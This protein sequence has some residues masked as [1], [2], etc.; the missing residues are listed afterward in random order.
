MGGGPC[1]L[2]DAVSERCDGRAMTGVGGMERKGMQDKAK[3]RLL[4]GVDG[5]AVGVGLVVIVSS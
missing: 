2:D 3:T 5:V 1:R 4:D